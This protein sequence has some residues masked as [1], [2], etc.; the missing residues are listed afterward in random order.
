MHATR[1][2]H[3][4]ETAYIISLISPYC[5]IRAE[6]EEE[7]EVENVGNKKGKSALSDSGD[8]IVAK[9]GLDEYDEEEETEMEGGAGESCVI[10]H[11]L[12]CN[13]HSDGF[14]R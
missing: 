14:F 1:K 11:G 13:I 3:T 10:V 12:L 7:N 5:R 4:H 6:E 9:Y 2:A 8:D